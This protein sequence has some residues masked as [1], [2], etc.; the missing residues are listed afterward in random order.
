MYACVHKN[1]TISIASLR[2]LLYFT[3]SS[4]RQRDNGQLDFC[5]ITFYTC[6]RSYTLKNVVLSQSSSI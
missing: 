6:D 5:I 2:D 1:D 3:Y 4:V